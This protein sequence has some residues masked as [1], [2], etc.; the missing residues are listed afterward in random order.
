MQDS[1]ILLKVNII[2]MLIVC[3]LVRQ[4]ILRRLSRFSTLS[5]LVHTRHT[6]GARQEG[7][8]RRGQA[9]GAD[10]R[11][12][13]EFYDLGTFYMDPLYSTI[14]GLYPT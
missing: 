12:I 4:G 13:G 14:F 7:P 2:D 3:I 5:A 11:Q 1:G 10:R 9:G 6:G 8:D